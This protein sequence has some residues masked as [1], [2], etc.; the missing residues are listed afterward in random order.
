MQGSYLFFQISTF[1]DCDFSTL[2]E[3]GN[4]FE[5]SVVE[6][7]DGINNVVDIMSLLSGVV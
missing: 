3:N 5:F 6:I 7:V 2:T 1:L 4:N